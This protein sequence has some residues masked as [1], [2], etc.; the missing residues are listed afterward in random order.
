M[1]QLDSL[2]RFTTGCTTRTPRPWKKLSE[3]IHQFNV[4]ARK[5]EAYAQ[6]EVAKEA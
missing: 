4:D 3:G 2:K 6:A 5:L 1:S